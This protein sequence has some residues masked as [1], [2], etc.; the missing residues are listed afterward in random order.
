MED[1][2][3]AGA[4]IDAAA[5]IGD[6]EPQSDAARIARRLFVHAKADLPGVLSES[7]GGR[8]VIAA[9]LAPDITFAA[10]LD[11]FP[12]VGCVEGKP[13]VVRAWDGG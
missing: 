7:Q 5:G 10:R 11:V 4:V 8:N 1:L 12:I 13:P 6:C 3:G 2:I 9:G